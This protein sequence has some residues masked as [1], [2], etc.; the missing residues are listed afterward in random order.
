VINSKNEL[1]LHSK[2]CSQNEISCPFD[3]CEEKL[4]FVELVNH[5]KIEHYEKFLAQISEEKVSKGIPGAWYGAE[6]VYQ[7]CLQKV[8]NGDPSK[9]FTSVV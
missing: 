6:N 4:G 8:A 7:G 9:L 3:K 1:E 2:L 5:I